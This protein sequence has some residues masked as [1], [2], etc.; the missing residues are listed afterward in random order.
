MS[1]HAVGLQR[2]LTRE[3]QSIFEHYDRMAEAIARCFGPACEVVVHSLEDTNRSV[4]KIVNGHVTGRT[5]GAPVTDLGL[6]ILAGAYGD[7][8]DVVGP[9]TS[10]SS[11]GSILHCVTNMIRNNKGKLIGFLCI[12][13]NMSASLAE[14]MT[15]FGSES[16]EGPK[17]SVQEHYSRNVHDLVEDS[18]RGVLEPLS[19]QKGISQLERNKRVVAELHAK[20]VFNIK[21][22]VDIVAELMGVSKFTVYNYLR[23]QRSD[24]PRGKKAAAKRP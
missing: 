1:T 14:V 2:K 10:T 23:E 16:R 15:A 19:L 21:G 20:G 17:S 8:D 3:E 12:N 24:E 22:A 13:F 11:T 6:E 7:S 18:Y 9:Y 5:V 4:V